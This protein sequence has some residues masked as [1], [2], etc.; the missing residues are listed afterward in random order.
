MT[1]A[2]TLF[3]EGPSD[4]T[5]SSW[6][7]SNCLFFSSWSKVAS[8]QKRSF[9]SEQLLSYSPASGGQLSQVMR[10]WCVGLLLCH[11]CSSA[12]FRVQ[13]ASC[14][15][16]VG[17]TIWFKKLLQYIYRS[18][19]RKIEYRVDLVYVFHVVPLLRSFINSVLSHE[20]SGSRNL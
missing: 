14:V 2:P 17:T 16:R 8:R 12:I 15:R 7:A 9:V 10:S 6:N 18:I 20:E 4:Q 3:V 19:S 13:R 11:S 1:H 5:S